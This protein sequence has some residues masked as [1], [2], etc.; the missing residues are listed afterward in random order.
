[1]K[2]KRIK[3][4][5]KCQRCNERVAQ[6]VV[7][8]FGET[9]CLPCYQLLQIENDR[10]PTGKGEV[11]VYD[12][13]GTDATKLVQKWAE[14][15]LAPFKLGNTTLYVTLKTSR[16]KE[17]DVCLKFREPRRPKHKRNWHRWIEGR[18]L[19]REDLAYPH[20]KKIAVS[21]C[22]IIDPVAKAFLPP[23][24]KGWFYEYDTV[25]FSDAAEAFAWGAGYV[26]FKLL[27]LVKAVPGLATKVG[28]QREAG[29]FLKKF[30]EWR[31][32]KHQTSSRKKTDQPLA[33]VG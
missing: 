25:T 26:M 19:V 4:D 2:A 7:E 32:K 8:I 6:Y 18:V 29:V 11:L 9:L 3:T 21:T 20:E 12:H 27:R 10:K 31:G 5:E 24:D 15:T 33:F 1:M 14:E 30:R 28:C 17:G 13:A 23:G 16:I 22:K